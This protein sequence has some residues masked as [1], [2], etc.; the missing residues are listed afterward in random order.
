MTVTL[1]VEGAAWKN[2]EKAAAEHGTTGEQLLQRFV[3]DAVLRENIGHKAAITYMGTPTENDKSFVAWM[4]RHGYEVYKIHEY[5]DDYAEDLGEDAET[6]TQADSGL[7]K[8]LMRTSCYF[9]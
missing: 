9:R 4:I 7:K 2:F 6:Y 3:Y 1:E 8:Y 5:Y